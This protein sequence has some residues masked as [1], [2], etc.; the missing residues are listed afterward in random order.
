MPVIKAIIFDTDGMVV[1]ADMFSVK[2]CAEY[3]VPYED[4]L[5]FFKNEFQPCLIGKADLKEKIKPYLI[6]WGW[7]NTVEDFLSYW[8]DAEHK[9][10]QRVVEIIYKLKQSGMKCYLATNQ[11]KYRTEYLRIQMKFNSIFD[12][13]FSSAEIGYRKPQPEFFYKVMTEI[14]LRKEEVQFWDDTEKN[15]LGAKEFGLDAKLY[16]SFEEFQTE[17]TKLLLKN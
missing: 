14:G 15:I 10:D 9:I 2:Y 16:Q 7:K 8:F 6:K 13:V 11:E 4:I 1:T 5:P 17:M 12:Q 3:N